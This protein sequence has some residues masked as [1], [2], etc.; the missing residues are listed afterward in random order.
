MKNRFIYSNPKA[1]NLYLLRNTDKRVTLGLKCNPSMKLRLAEEAQSMGIT[2]SQ[3]VEDL[4]KNDDT[5]KIN[6]K[7]L[8]LTKKINFYENNVLKELLEEN[9][10]KE[11]DYKDSSGVILKKKI[12]SIEDIFTVLVNSFKKQ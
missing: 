1:L 8:E 5:K 3:H 9:R 7:F 2:L 11:I 4:L 12:N 10:N 6:T